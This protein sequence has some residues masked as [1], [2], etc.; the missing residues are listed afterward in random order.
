MSVPVEGVPF[1]ASSHNKKDG[2]GLWRMLWAD[3][4]GKR[5][6]FLSSAKATVANQLTFAGLFAALMGAFLIASYVSLSPDPLEEILNVLKTQTC[7]LEQT[8][9]SSQHNCTG[10]GNDMGSSSGATGTVVPV[11][12]L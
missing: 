6:E 2:D 1:E 7:L 3:V 9:N 8:Q 12:I 5:A 11:N 4:K 10:S